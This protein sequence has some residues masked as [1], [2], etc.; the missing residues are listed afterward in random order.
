ML[1]HCRWTWFDR[2]TGLLKSFCADLLTEANVAHSSVAQ[3]SLFIYFTDSKASNSMPLGKKTKRILKRLADCA[4]E[5]AC[6]VCYWTY[7][8][9]YLSPEDNKALLVTAKDCLCDWPEKCGKRPGSTTSQDDV[10]KV[11]QALSYLSLSDW[12]VWR[13]L[14]QPSCCCGTDFTVKRGIW[15]KS[16]VCAVYAAGSRALLALLVVEQC[17]S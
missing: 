16:M 2:S 5:R 1:S 7:I 3:D 10:M 15:N 9:Q 4:D 12:D 13:G 14:T 8:E 11:L 6:A 17:F